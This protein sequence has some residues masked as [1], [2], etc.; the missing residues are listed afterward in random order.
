MYLTTS[1]P[2]V[3]VFYVNIS[4]SVKHICL[5][6]GTMFSVGFQLRHVSW[7]NEFIFSRSSISSLQSLEVYIQ[8]D[9]MFMICGSIHSRFLLLI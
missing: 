8:L 9:V 4:L 7:F 5:R 1:A 2:H 3:L 6:L